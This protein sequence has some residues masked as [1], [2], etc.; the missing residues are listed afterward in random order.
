EAGLAVVGRA[1]AGELVGL[2]HQAAKRLG[3]LLGGPGAAVG[4]AQDP[5]VLG[6]LTGLLESV[7]MAQ[8]AVGELV[9]AA[10]ETGVAQRAAKT[11]AGLWL[12]LTARLTPSQASKIVLTSRRAAPF[13][14]LRAAAL[15]GRANQHQ[16]AA[17]A[18]VLD[19][20]P[21]DLDPALA[22]RA[23]QRLVGLASRFA[24]DGLAKLT[25]A[26]FEQVAPQAAQEAAE[27]KAARQL[28]RADRKRFFSVRDNGDGTHALRGLLASHDGEL[29]R[30]A[31]DKIADQRRREPAQAPGGT[32]PSR[33][34]AKADALVE[35]CKH[36]HACANAT[37]LGGAGAKLVIAVRAED[38]PAPFPAGPPPNGPATGPAPAP[39]SAPGQGGRIVATG[40]RIDTGLLAQIAC[41]SH[42]ARALLGARGEVLEIGRASR[43]VPK[44]IRLAAA[45]RDQGC[46]F[47]SCDRPPE[48]CE[49]H[50]AKPWNQGGPTDLTN[51]CTLCPV[52]HRLVEPAR[53]GPDGW[54][55]QLRHDGLWEFIPPKWYDPD[56]RPMLHHRHIAAGATP[57]QP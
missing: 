18:G 1:D 15:A 34:Q 20:L 12:Q 57:S 54:K 36:A 55:P 11:P 43:T 50:H 32:P 49:C 25:Q 53:A 27:A 35:I 14:A 52:H 33:A 6:Q 45:L 26:V 38:L 17:I 51:I 46:C 37:H 22:A 13:K 3:G 7:N 48:V 23:E 4:L 42:V 16:V 56:Q 47:P 5:A 28:E 41:D 9:T 2:I 39:G 29:V 40:Q 24:S 19:D 30:A 10:E 31:L 21:R 8:A 44:A